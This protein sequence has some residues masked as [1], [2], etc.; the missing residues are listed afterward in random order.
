MKDINFGRIYDIF[1]NCVEC[2]RERKIQELEDELEQ[3]IA[4]CIDTNYKLWHLE[5]IARMKELGHERISNTKTEID[6]TNQIRND[7]IQ[8]ID[9]ELH[10]RLNNIVHDDL[11]KFNTETPGMLIDRLTIL[12]IKKSKIE[13]LI[14]IIEEDDLKDEFLEKQ[15]II[16]EQ[17]N[18]FGNFL[19]VYFVKVSRGEWF[20]LP[21]Q[22][23][24]LY[25]N[26]KVQKY[27]KRIQPQD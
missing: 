16:I 15:K 5:D 23:L 9:R 8:R 1:C 7:L 21:Q 26:E 27:I 19:D 11:E 3:L 22:P 25:N 13:E 17:I 4:K 10:D 14:E 12:F 18:K 24:K 20:F 6:L 2:Q